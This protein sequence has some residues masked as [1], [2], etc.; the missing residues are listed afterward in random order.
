MRTSRIIICFLV[1]V[2][3]AHC[4]FYYSALPEKM[5][6]HFNGFGEADA[7]MLKTNFFI[8]EGVILFF[9]LAEFTLIPYLIK[10]SPDSLI[11]LPNKKYWLAKERREETFSAIG[12]YFEWFAILLLCLFIA[13]N[14]LV[15]RAN[16]LK[17]NLSPLAMWLILGAFFA[18]TIFWLV[19]FLRRFKIR[20]Y[21][22]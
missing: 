8:F 22:N 12:E 14:Q 7:W 16:L 17:E 6:S 10:I 5:A 3:L 9:I 2:F 21:E 18:F 20:K 19:K 13:I 4:A 1:G 15:F 11:N